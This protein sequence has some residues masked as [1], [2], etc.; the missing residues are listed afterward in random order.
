MQLE[1]KLEFVKRKDQFECRFNLANGC[2]IPFLLECVEDFRAYLLQVQEQ[3]V[4]EQVAK[5]ALEDSEKVEIDQVK[6]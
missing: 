5:K 2:P 4:A 6:E 1:N 3:Q